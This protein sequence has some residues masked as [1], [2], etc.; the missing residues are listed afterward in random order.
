VSEIGIVFPD[1][2]ALFFIFNNLVA[3]FFTK[4]LGV[5]YSDL[6]PRIWGSLIPSMRQEPTVRKNMTVATAPWRWSDEGE[7]CMSL[8][9]KDIPAWDVDFC[10]VPRS[11]I[12]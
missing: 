6:G 12:S 10:W 1:S 3:L 11:L 4:K 9:P 8:T 7:K 5:G 2:E